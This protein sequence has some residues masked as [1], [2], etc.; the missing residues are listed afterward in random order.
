MVLC[1]IRSSDAS[2]H[3]VGDD[4]FLYKINVGSTYQYYE[5]IF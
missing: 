1:P 2:Q 4:L 3:R 5:D